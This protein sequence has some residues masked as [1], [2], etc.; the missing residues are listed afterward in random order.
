MT[1]VAGQVPDREGQ[2]IVDLGAGTGNLTGKL[3]VSASVI[4]VDTSARMF[5][6][7]RQKL[8]GRQVTYIEDDILAFLTGRLEPCDAIVSTYALHHLTS[9]EKAM[10]LRAMAGQLRPGGSIVIGDLMFQNA[11]ARGAALE[12]YR[13]SGQSD[14]A[15]DI[16]DEFFWDLEVDQQ[17]LRDAGFAL[18]TRQFS[19]LSRGLCARRP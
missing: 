5:K 13:S 19:D 6:I 7:A 10:A 18:E 14:L 1:W 15:Q 3:P 11:A 16:E 4:A 2:T 8:K 17:T 12:H 9:E